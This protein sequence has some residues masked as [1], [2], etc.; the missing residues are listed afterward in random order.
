[1]RVDS[2]HLSRAGVS[3]LLTTSAAG[4][5]VL[6]HWGTALGPVDPTSAA[7]LLTPGVPHSALDD[8]RLRGVVGENV[9]GFTGLPG[10]E[11]FRPGAKEAAWAPRLRDWSWHLDEDDDARLTLSS[12]D[13]ESGWGVRVDLE[14]TREGLVRTR[15]HITNTG[16]GALV[17][18]AVRCALPVAPRAT[19]LLDM[20]GRWCRE[21][22]PQR[23]PWLIGT[24][25]REGR[26]GRTGHDATLLMVAGTP[27]FGFGAGEVW[28]THVAWSGDHAAYAERTI[29]GEC[30]LGGGELLGPG[31]VELQEG[32]TYTS[33]WL[34]GS[35]STSGLDHAS[36]RIHGWL[37]RQLPLNQRPVLIN[38]WEAVYFDHDLQGLTD[39]VDAAAGVGV[40]RFVLDD[41]WFNGRRSDRAGLGDWTVGAE[42]WPDGLHP[43]I[44]RVHAAGMDFG[45]WV[46]PEMVNEDSDVAREHPDWILRGRGE[47]PPT[48]RHQQVLDLQDPDAYAHVRDALM[49]IL[50]EYPIAFLKWDHNR[51]LIDVAHGGRP[52]VHGQTEAFYRLLD[53]LRAA[54]PGLE[55]ESCSSGGARIDLEVLTRTDRVWPSDTIDAVER[56]RIQRWTSLLVP[57]ERL[58]AHVGG[59]V[60]HTTGRHASL[61]FRAATALLGHFGLEWDVR[62]LTDAERE[63]LSAW[64][65]LHKRIRPLLA[66]GRLVRGDDHDP[67]VV[68]SGI[69]DPTGAEGWYVVATVDTVVTQAPPPVLLPGLDPDRSYTVSVETPASTSPAFDLGT[70]WRDGEPVEATGALLTTLGVRL[71][72]MAPE[73]AV[74]LRAQAIS[75][76]SV[77]D[78]P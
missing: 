74:V 72:V 63:E 17:L 21:R 23:R 35:H 46:E 47:L 3:V 12:T 7:R 37:R 41:G 62:R 5:P 52:A 53:E 25:L 71:P 43:L 65:A 78:Q 38:T 48:W 24:H 4:V 67:A 66:A 1:M 64:V 60:A 18:T 13:A 55:I 57:P 22:T 8:P 75:Q 33:P 50:D 51:D 61:G 20:T 76:R 49:A 42:Q 77:A 6:L 32:A 26:H 30:L 58:G 14:L 36:A 59:P 45:L 31:E 11:G 39:L 15:T 70:T 28:A 44:E 19:E 2:V 69:V 27:A 56:Q 34:V 54:H 40:E 16:T 73:T 9:A 29:E 10:L 68:V